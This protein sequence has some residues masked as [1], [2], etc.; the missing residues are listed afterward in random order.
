MLATRGCTIAAR[1]ERDALVGQSNDVQNPFDAKIGGDSAE[2]VRCGR[3]LDWRSRIAEIERRPVIVPFK[4]DHSPAELRQGTQR[5]NR[6]RRVMEPDGIS[7]LRFLSNMVQ[8][9]CRGW[10]PDT[11]VDQR[12]NES[13]VRLLHQLLPWEW[14]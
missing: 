13:Q 3:R 5:A 4:I 10:R 6:L 7:S 9:T 8:N 11:A 14:T 2:I 12:R 1:G